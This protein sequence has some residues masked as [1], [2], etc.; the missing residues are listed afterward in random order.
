MKMPMRLPCEPRDSVSYLKGYN[1]AKLDYELRTVNKMA[2]K[3]IPCT[4]PPSDDRN[5]FITRGESNLMTCCIGHY[6]HDVKRWYE[7]RDWFAKPI[8]DCG[9]WCDIPEL[10]KE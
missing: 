1:D 3:W 2:D 4:Q 8:Y 7:D 9:Y 6:E 10:P 5:V